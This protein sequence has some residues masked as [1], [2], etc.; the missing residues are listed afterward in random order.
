MNFLTIAFTTTK[1]KTPPK[2]LPDITR[3]EAQSWFDGWWAG[4]AVGF[5]CGAGVG[6]LLVR[7]V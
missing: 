3:A 4:I 2:M 5:V 6:A 1:K 7:F